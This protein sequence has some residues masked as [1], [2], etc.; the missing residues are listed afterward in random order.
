M[1][2]LKHVNDEELLTQN[3]AEVY[4]NTIWFPKVLL[5]D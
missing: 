5:A 4:K 3:I 2:Q 1:A